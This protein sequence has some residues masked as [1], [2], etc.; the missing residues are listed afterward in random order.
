MRTAHKFA[1]A[2]EH[3]RADMVA[4]G[5]FPQLSQRY[6][7]MAVPKTVI[8]ETTSFEGAV[9]EDIFL[10]RVLEVAGS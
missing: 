7:V 6:Q 4:A 5:E 8:N 2:S 1:M 10:Q 9:P 3:V